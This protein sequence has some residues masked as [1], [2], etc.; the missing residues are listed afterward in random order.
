MGWDKVKSRTVL[1]EDA[2]AFLCAGLI[3]KGSTREVHKAHLIDNHVVKIEK[4]TDSFRNIAE[5]NIW[6]EVMDKPEHAK[7][8][9]KVHSLSHNGR[10]LVMERTVVPGPNDWPDMLPEYISDRH[11]GNFGMV[12]RKDPKTRKMVHQ[13]VC[14]D[15]GHND[16]LAQGL[17][18]KMTKVK[19]EKP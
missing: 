1:G 19:W 13:F 7:W 18:A 14:H 9:A 12:L 17:S 6:C 16:M 8:F 5:F 4:R 2:I 11:R 15:Y 10:I 3:G